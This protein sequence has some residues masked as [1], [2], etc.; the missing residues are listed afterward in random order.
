MEGE[1]GLF[2][3]V[4]E[5]GK[6]TGIVIRIEFKDP[7]GPAYKKAGECEEM[8]LR[9]LWNLCV[10]PEMCEPRPT[11]GKPAECMLP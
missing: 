7:S 9:E 4:F 8:C 6:D 11:V 1:R 5:A 10:L 3:G 2:V